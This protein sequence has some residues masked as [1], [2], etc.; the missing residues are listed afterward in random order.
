[1]VEAPN[2][3]GVIPTSMSYVYTVFQ[4]L[5]LPWMG[6]WVYLY[7]VTPV[8]VGEILENWVMAEPK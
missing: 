3:L 8:E 4:H 1:M 7:T 2:P 5:D 6:I